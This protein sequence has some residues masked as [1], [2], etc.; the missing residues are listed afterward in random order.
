MKLSE[1][2]T[3]LAS[4]DARSGAIEATGVTADSRKVKRGD[5][6][7]AVPGTKADGLA[8]AA[9][10]VVAG[11]AAIVGEGSPPALP[12]GAAFVKVEN[13]RR[14]LSLLAA[15]IFPRQPKVKPTPVP[16]EDRVGP[17]VPKA[18][19]APKAAPAPKPER[20]VVNETPETKPAPVPK[21]TPV[22]RATPEPKISKKGVKPSPTVDEGADPE[23]VERAKFTQ[24]KAKALEAELRKLRPLLA[25]NG[26]IWASW[27][28]KAAKVE[29]DITEDTIRKIALPMG[30]VDVKVC[31]VDETWS[32]LK[33]VIRK[34]ER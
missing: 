16:K 6:F 8:Y 1:L 5:V 27:P 3:G 4:L 2:F 33:L 12:A 26:A 14:A 31:A 22:P 28:K 24:A 17:P 10:A 19:P 13:A 11:A 21:A 15:R 29:T 25:A 9:Q 18:T 32:G 34:G 23:T 7:V 30:Y 20:A